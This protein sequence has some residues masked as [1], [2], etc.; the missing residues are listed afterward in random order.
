MR[1][2][3]YTKVV[4]TII[5]VALC[6]IAL[7]RLETPDVMA[8]SER[9]PET[10]MAEQRPQ[11][12]SRFVPTRVGPLRWRIPFAMERNEDSSSLTDECH[13][14]IS[15]LNAAPGSTEVEVGFWNESGIGLGGTAATVAA[16]DSWVLGTSSPG[17]NDLYPF[18]ANRTV[19]TGLF[20]RG[21]AEVRADDPRILV[22]AFLVCRDDSGV[23]RTNSMTTLPAYPVGATA[24]YFQAGM[25]A[26]WT[27]P[28]VE[29][30][31]PE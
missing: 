18:R 7:P 24:Q 11:E 27:P 29:P 17:N 19:V 15:F 12:D 3:R 25:P 21:F 8:A 6:V 14:S 20:Y 4:L 9:L 23:T 10:A 5:A 30:E 1:S 2:D 16:H 13:T 31:V 28:M 22:A 26:T